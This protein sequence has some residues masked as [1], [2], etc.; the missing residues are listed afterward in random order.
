MS[1]ARAYLGMQCFWGESAFAKM[2]AYCAGYTDFSELEELKKQHGLSDSLVERMDCG[3]NAG[4][5]KGGR[6][7]YKQLG[8]IYEAAGRPRDPRRIVSSRPCCGPAKNR[9]PEDEVHFSRLTTP[10][11]D[12]P[13]LRHML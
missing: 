13:P 7:C 3:H 9:E 6:R 4:T 11:S 10:T 8:E 1:L 5:L 12:S 2:N